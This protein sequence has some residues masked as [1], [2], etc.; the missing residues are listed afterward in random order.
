MVGRQ[1][2]LAGAVHESAERAWATCMQRPPTRP[3]KTTF[4][5]VVVDMRKFMS[6]AHELRVRWFCGGVRGGFGTLDLLKLTR[7]KSARLTPT[8]QESH[9]S[10]AE[11]SEQV[12]PAAR[13][14]PNFARLTYVRFHFGNNVDRSPLLASRQAVCTSSHEDTIM[15]LSDVSNA[16]TT[17]DDL[18]LLSDSR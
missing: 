15:P 5:G 10:R 13:S 4:R 17:L 3:R 18:R 14:L 12:P 1:T 6:E 7:G 16:I 11:S 2:V 9:I 8:Q